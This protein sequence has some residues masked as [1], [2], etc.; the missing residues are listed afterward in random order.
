MK[1][2]FYA[3][4]GVVMLTG[5]SKEFSDNLTTLPSGEQIEVTFGA[6]LTLDTDAPGT[7]AQGSFAEPQ[8]GFIYILDSSG[9]LIDNI[10][11]IKLEIA[12]DG[13]MTTDPSKVMLTAGTAYTFRSVVEPKGGSL[14]PTTVLPMYSLLNQEGEYPDLLSATATQKISVGAQVKFA[15]NHLYGKVKF[16]LTAGDNFNDGDLESASLLVG[17]YYAEGAFNIITGKMTTKS[18]STTVGVWKEA[19]YYAIPQTFTAPATPF[20]QVIGADGK[21]YIGKITNGDIKPNKLT[22]ITIK[23]TGEPK[24]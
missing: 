3:I 1:K 15:Y 5:C 20:A 22:T 24:P 9:N 21:S 23:V 4:L 12:Q 11:P 7:R 18:S 10:D 8:Q 17:G 19:I 2:I 13:T 6:S 14:V 16:M